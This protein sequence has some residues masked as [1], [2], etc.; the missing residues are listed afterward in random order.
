M[1]DLPDLVL[2]AR[3]VVTPEETRPASVHVR[4]GVIVAVAGWDEVPAGC[5]LHEAADDEVMMPGLV[6]TH[7]HVNEPG[8]TDWEGFATATGAA[9][10]GGVTTLVDMPLNSI[11]ATTSVAGL[12]AKANAARGKVRVDVGFW[13]GVV[14]G[15]HAE[16][17]PL[18]N[19]GVLGFKCFLAPTGVPEFV[20]VE[21][22]DL[23][24]ALPAIAEMGVPLLVHAE[25]PGPLEAAASA[26]AGPPDPRSYLRYLRSRPREAE[27][28]A[29]ALLVRLAREHRARVHVV[30]L[31][32]A[33]AVPLLREARAAGVEVTV[34]SC[35]HYLHF[36]A[37]EIPAGGTDYKCAPPI[38][39]F[40]NREKLWDA[41]SEGVIDLIASDH[42]PAPPAL[43]ELES[44]DFTRAWGGIASLGLGLS[45]IWFEASARGHTAR[46]VA[47]WMCRAP[48]RLAGLG[49]RKGEITVGHDADLVI[50][51]P[52]QDRLVD[53]EHLHF[54][55]PV[56]P[57]LGA[58]LPGV[59]RSTW[60]RGEPVY[61]DGRFPGPPRGRLLLPGE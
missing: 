53:P 5:H 18:R 57:Y 38:R 54:R 39:S 60:V 61:Q 6:D 3:H 59:V 45:T 13:G 40:R 58:I 34:E 19:A 1:A 24:E 37:E 15:N 30:H 21:E 48:A 56:S 2:R 51:A 43:K 42:S 35:P 4:G 55:H 29:V 49:D 41:L 12:R 9:A 31:A 10:A 28:E 14:P 23:R 26:E 20:M 27:N 16:L 25:L 47:E 32:S 11:P 52:E 33:D 46:Q 8:R 22:G 50:W 7:V 44:G 17:R 36:A